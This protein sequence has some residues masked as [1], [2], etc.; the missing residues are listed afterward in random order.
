MI[1]D[2]NKKSLLIKRWNS[3][4]NSD[5]SIDED[6]SDSTTL[7]NKFLD[8]YNNEKNFEYLENACICI[9]NGQ[10]LDLYSAEN[11]KIIFNEIGVNTRKKFR[12]YINRFDYVITNFELSKDLIEDCVKSSS[13]K[14]F[15]RYE[16]LHSM[17]CGDKSN[18]IC[19]NVPFSGDNP[20]AYLTKNFIDQ[21]KKDT[22]SLSF[23]QYSSYLLNHFENGII[24]D[25]IV[26]KP[27]VSVSDYGRWYWGGKD[28]LQ[29]NKEL[30]NNIIEK[31]LKNG[32]KYVSVDLVSASS[33]MLA[34]ITKSKILKALVASRIK[35]SEDST[36]S[37]N[38][39]ELLNIFVHGNEDPNNLSYYMKKKF[40]LDYISKVG[41]FNIDTVLR[42]LYEELQDYNSNIIDTYKSSLVY[43]E[44]KRRIVNPD[45]IIS[46]DKDIIKKHR[47][48][49]QGHV[50]DNII[51]LTKYV[52]NNTGILP[53]YTVHDCVNFYISKNQDYDLFI[54]TV[55]NASKEIKLPY[56]I[57]E[58]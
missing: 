27:R 19:D 34:K 6:I 57:E 47:I 23:Y 39:K 24:I 49:L 44:L 16:I 32:D 42:K 43:K 26:I 28:K 37:S 3:F 17:Y 55:K 22:N 5:I 8:L 40:D 35:N 29:N 31:I 9:K 45:A 48:Y 50:H 33:S 10:K 18:Y 15:L 46:N 41:K 7:F 12:K 25:D 14:M 20:T 36:Y 52:Y 21:I 54:N 4:F 30:Q 13:N 51:L 53:L 2:S 56:R 58:Y 11:N 1:I 38:L